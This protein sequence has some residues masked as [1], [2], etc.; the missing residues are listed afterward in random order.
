[1]EKNKH[2]TTNQ[3]VPVSNN[4]SSLTIGER[5]PVLLRVLVPLGASKFT[6]TWQ[7]TRVRSF[8]KIP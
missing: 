2:L 1:M 4:Q 3:G 6:R 5:G 8:C 7:S